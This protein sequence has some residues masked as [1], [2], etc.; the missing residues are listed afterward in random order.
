MA[1]EP[2]PGWRADPDR[3]ASLDASHLQLHALETGHYRVDIDPVLPSIG[4]VIRSRGLP[5]VQLAAEDAARELIADMA[6]A[7]GGN[8]IW[9]GARFTVTVDGVQFARAEGPRDRALQE[10]MHY[11]SGYV[12]DG[13]PRV[14]VWEKPK[15]GAAVRV[16]AGDQ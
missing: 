1:R 16:W 2:L 13:E 11:A 3:G 6:E 12:A 15:R 14:E 8:V 9:G 10:A 7:L 4:V 5:A